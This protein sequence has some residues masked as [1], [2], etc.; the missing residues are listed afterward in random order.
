[1]VTSRPCK[2]ITLVVVAATAGLFFVALANMELGLDQQLPVLDGGNLYNFFGDVKRYLEMG[3]VGS[4]VVRNADYTDATT[5]RVLDDLVDLIS[6]RKDLTI[7]PWR[8]WYKS[9]QSILTQAV[10]IPH[11]TKV[12]FPGVDPKPI[13]D[14]FEALTDA[15]LRM[16]L[17]HPCC[18]QFG[19]CG[20]QFYEDII[21]KGVS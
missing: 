15:F 10:V 8:I 19:I 6:R 7:P 16:N 9:V 11:L 13:L 21:R 3:P 12:C 2:A 5:R 20:G 4:L 17:D 18:K 1:M 14:D